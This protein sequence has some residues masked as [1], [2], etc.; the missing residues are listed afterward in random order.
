[1]NCISCGK[2]TNNPKFCSRSCSA[3]YTNSKSPKRKLKRTCVRDGCKDVVRNHRSTLCENHYVEYASL[4]NTSEMRIIDY[5]NKGSLKN[6]HRSSAY[7][8]IRSLARYHN[9]ELLSLPCANC[10]YDKHV[11][12]CHIKPISKF[13]IY[14]KI[15]NVNSRD[16]LIQ[17]CPNCHW[18][19]DNL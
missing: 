14:E 16:N 2:E 10:G 1:M 3:S 5:I 13:D 18:E 9:K 11:E 4:I 17:L 12:L 15:K 7:V 8:H 19:F 6:L